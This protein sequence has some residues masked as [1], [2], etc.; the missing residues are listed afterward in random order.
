MKR[1]FLGLVVLLSIMSISAF[2][3]EIIIESKDK[4]G[5]TKKV[6]EKQYSDPVV[7]EPQSAPASK[8]YDSKT[9]PTKP[10]KQED[11]VDIIRSSTRILKMSD[12]YVT[13]SWMVTLKNKT[14][15][16]R[17][18]SINIK[19]LD[20]KGFM[21]KETWGTFYLDSKKRQEFSDTKMI[22]KALYS[23]IKSHKAIIRIY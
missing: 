12:R 22:E 4:D 18:G 17:Q 9:V 5:T 21:L 10:I 13:L 14:R 3:G 23:Q 15:Q 19:F 20:K 2:A 11:I 1:M 8:Y 7:T 6:M 16:P